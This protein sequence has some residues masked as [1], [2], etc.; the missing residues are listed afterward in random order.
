MTRDQ[1]I[2]FWRSAIRDWEAF[3]QKAESCKRRF[4][5]RINLAMKREQERAALKQNVEEKSP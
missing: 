2:E 5:K 3:N 1:R 4:K